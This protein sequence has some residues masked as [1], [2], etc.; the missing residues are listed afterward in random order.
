MKKLLLLFLFSSSLFASSMSV[1]LGI[2]NVGIFKNS[3]YKSDLNP[4]LD[5]EYR[6]D[7]GNFEVGPGISANVINVDS[8]RYAVITNLSL[9]TRYNFVNN[10][11]FKVYT[12]LNIGY[13]YIFIKTYHMNNELQ[14][15]ET[16]LAYELKFGFV[17]NNFD[18]NLGI[19]TTILEYSKN[20]V[21]YEDQ[22]KRI[23]VSVGYLLF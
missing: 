7:L 14:F 2:E 5:L 22:L 8:V 19:G 12:Q 13:P 1:S 11:N 10:E 6:F 15:F 21:M 20:D 17:K 18:M 9:N 16:S 3:D 23:S 4:R